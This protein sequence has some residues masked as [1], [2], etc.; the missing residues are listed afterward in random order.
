MSAQ[1]L[2]AAHR[3]AAAREHRLRGLFRRKAWL[4]RALL[5]V[6]VLI[7]GV[8][9]AWSTLVLPGQG[10]AA[11]GV[12][13]FEVAFFPGLKIN[14]LVWAGQ[15]WRLLSSTFVHLGV[16]HLLFNSYGLYALGPAVE[17]FFG[18][19]RFL[20]I[21][22]L[23]GLVASAASLLFTEAAAGGASG[24]IYALAGALISF[25]FKYR[26]QLPE[27]FTRLLT[28]QMLPWIIFGIGIGFLPG[29]P[30][31]N[32]AHIGGLLAG[33]VLGFGLG[34]RLTPPARWRQVG[35]WCVTAVIA[36]L[37]AATFFFWGQE[38]LR[39]TATP[40]AMGSCY[41]EFADVF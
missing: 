34:S 32:G 13:W 7:F 31:D 2:L 24:A 1:E 40:E 37:L 28:R 19:R 33:G 3:D 5:A 29:I 26:D 41:A 20:A 14:R 27:R 39:C 6:L 12:S 22:V 8:S 35:L 17:K 36:A 38:T 30:F 4:N 18:T 16:L 25:G 15:W 21:Y 11:P 23:G 9:W 10:L